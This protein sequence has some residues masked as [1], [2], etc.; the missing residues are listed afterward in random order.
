MIYSRRTCR[1]FWYIIIITLASSF[2]TS[3]Y[4]ATASPEALWYHYSKIA[5]FAYQVVALLFLTKLSWIKYISTKWHIL[6][7]KH[8]EYWWFFKN[9]PAHLSELSDRISLV[10]LS[11]NFSH[12][13]LPMNH[14][15]NFNKTRQKASLGTGHSSFANEG[16]LLFPRVNNNEIA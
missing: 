1:K 5:L 2:I 14:W 10:R 15:A 8:F 11:V 13:H 12:V 16:P 7:G 9:F 4:L 3:G 6:G